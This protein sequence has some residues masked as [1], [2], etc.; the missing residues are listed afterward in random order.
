MASEEQKRKDKILKF[1]MQINRTAEKILMLTKKNVLEVFTEDQIVTIKR[2]TRGEKNA[3][4]KTKGVEKTGS[5]K[6]GDKQGEVNDNPDSE[7]TCG[8]GEEAKSESTTEG[9]GQS[10]K[11]STNQTGEHSEEEK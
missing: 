10:Q 6:D 8:A 3:T 4:N 1:A 2:V 11:E 9:E 5:D 7:Q